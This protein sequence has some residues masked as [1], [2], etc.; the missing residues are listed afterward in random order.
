MRSAPWALLALFVIAGCQGER[1][2]LGGKPRPKIY[3]RVVSLS[4]SMSE[5]TTKM[6]LVLVGR[7][8]ACN[9]PENIV[10]AAV[11]AEVKPNY[12]RL[13]QVKPDLVVVDKALF[14]EAEIAKIK[15]T[16][17]SDVIE[18]DVHT[19]DDLIDFIDALAG[20]IGGE[21]PAQ[22][23]LDDIRKQRAIAQASKPARGVNAVILMGD[24]AGGYMIAG[25]G[26]FTADLIRSAGASVLGP[27]ADKFVPANLEQLLTWNPDTIFVPGKADSLLKD[28]RLASLKAI[29]S[30]RVAAASPDLMLRAGA[31]VDGMISRAAQ[32]IQRGN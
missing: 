7:T 32:F 3:K 13:L 26:S 18:M 15:A 29:K 10:Q 31:R 16:A 6:D 30:G 12:E 8:A 2:T 1:M 21:L 27:D 11:V 14:S 22:K 4:P 9:Y 23:Y 25:R 28:P 20:R 5:I 17:K 24:S 19:V